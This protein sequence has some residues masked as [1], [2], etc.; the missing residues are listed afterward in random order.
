[1]IFSVD[2]HCSFILNLIYDLQ[3]VQRRKKS[4]N[5]NIIFFFWIFCSWLFVRQLEWEK[6]VNIFVECSKSIC[7]RCVSNMFRF[8]SFTGHI[9]FVPLYFYT[10]LHNLYIECLNIHVIFAKRK[11]RSRKMVRGFEYTSKAKITPASHLNIKQ[12]I[13]NRQDD[14]HFQGDS[15]WN[16]CIMY[17]K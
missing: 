15:N 9:N 6:N 16:S 5:R 1:M 3:S 10:I 12:Q 13:V 7:T 4:K 14:F 8:N 17:L 11:R 2:K